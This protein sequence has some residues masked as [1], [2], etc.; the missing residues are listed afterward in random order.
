MKGYILE[1]YDNM[2][3]SY[4]CRRLMEEAGKRNMDLRTLGVHD[5]YLQISG[6]SSVLMH[7]GYE[8]EQVD[9]AF[10]RYKWGHL[11][12]EAATLA[13]HCY[14]AP[15]P[16]SL[17]VNKYEQLKRLRSTHFEVPASLL[18]TAQFP[19][20]TAEKLLGN[21]FVAKGLES[22]M[23]REIFLITGKPGWDQL[24]DEYGPEKE[25]ILQQFIEDSFGKDMRIFSLRGEAVAA[26]ERRSGSDFRANVA[27]GA[28]TTPLEI[29]EEIRLIC[30]DLYH[31]TGLDFAGVDLLYGQEKPWLCEINVMPG[32]EGM[33]ETTGV[34]IAGLMMDMVLGDVQ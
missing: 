10:L 8:A 6:D 14:N 11:K 22:S 4:T 2:K 30:K 19:Y 33:E 17:Y 5:S 3:N 34:N 9:F 29:T 1:R 18:V 20:D 26:M 12:E 7:K 21:P 27:L 13:K 24:R 31:R 25:W 16:F 32:I 28:Q 23:G 15:G